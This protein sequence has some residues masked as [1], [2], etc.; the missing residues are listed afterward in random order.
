M[1]PPRHTDRGQALSC[2]LAGLV[3]ILRCDE[4]VK[5]VCKDIVFNNEGMGMVV[6]ICSRKT[7]QLREA[8]ANLIIART[9]MIACPVDMMQ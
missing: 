8:P 7:D 9:G 2:V 4:L 1:D 6:N 5:I 3:E